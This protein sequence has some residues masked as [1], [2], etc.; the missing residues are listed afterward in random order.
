MYRS[1]LNWTNQMYRSYLKCKNADMSVMLF[2]L[3]ESKHGTWMLHAS[4]IFSVLFH[5]S[6]IYSTIFRSVK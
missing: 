1:Y 4:L 5:I 3:I 2:H 6:V